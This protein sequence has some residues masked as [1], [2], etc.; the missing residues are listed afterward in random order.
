M[1]QAT[2]VDRARALTEIIMTRGEKYSE[3]YETYRKELEDEGVDPTNVAVKGRCRQRWG[4]FQLTLNDDRYAV[5]QDARRAYAE[6]RASGMSPAEAHNAA[7]SAFSDEAYSIP[8]A[9]DAGTERV[10]D[11]R[12]YT[13]FEP[14]LPDLVTT[15]ATFEQGLG[16]GIVESISQVRAEIIEVQELL[17][18][19]H[20]ESDKRLEARFASIDDFR[21]HL[22]VELSAGRLSAEEYDRYYFV[23][24]IPELRE[25]VVAHLPYELLDVE[26]A[27][28]GVLGWLNADMQAAMEKAYGKRRAT[29]A[30]PIQALR[31]TGN[32]SA[33]AGVTPRVLKRALREAQEASGVTEPYLG[34]FAQIIAD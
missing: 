4:K 19:T 17:G 34:L 16:Q 18:F 31:T 33:I 26:V 12:R 1:L 3:V 10:L 9:T 15:S 5:L 30:A 20:G 6:M 32:G 23:E 21:A 22:E 27:A 29:Y 8:Y 25:Y 7:W 28:S 11:L 24:S 13:T 2:G 14:D